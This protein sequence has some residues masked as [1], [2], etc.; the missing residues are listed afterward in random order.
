V[1]AVSRRASLEDFLRARARAGEI[2]RLY[3]YR[4]TIS[5]EPR[6][7][8]LYREFR[9]FGE[10]RDALERLPAELSRHRPFIRNVRDIAALG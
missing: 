6:Y 1:T 7:G 10:A 5:G 3:V 8:V 4:T 2:E 9:T